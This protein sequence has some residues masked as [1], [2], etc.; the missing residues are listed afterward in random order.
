[1]FM[2]I[3]YALVECLHEA[4]QSRAGINFKDISLSVKGDGLMQHSHLFLKPHCLIPLLVH[5]LRILFGVSEQA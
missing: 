4:L 1:M 5:L 3:S 2:P